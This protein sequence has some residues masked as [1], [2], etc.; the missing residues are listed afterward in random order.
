MQAGLFIF[1]LCTRATS[2]PMYLVYHSPFVIMLNS[3]TG[4]VDDTHAM[5]L[6]QR[7]SEL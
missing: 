3:Q 2:E 6:K 5:S 7:Q 1:N 4:H